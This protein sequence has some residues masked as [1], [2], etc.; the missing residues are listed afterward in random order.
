MENKTITRSFCGCKSLKK[1]NI[2]PHQNFTASYKQR[3]E[4][5]DKLQ[6]TQNI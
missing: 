5:L 2:E 1:E 3:V 4:A 6:S